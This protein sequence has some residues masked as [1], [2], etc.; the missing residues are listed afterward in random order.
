MTQGTSGSGAKTRSRLKRSAPRPIALEPRIMYDGAAVDT[1]AA[2]AAAAKQTSNTATDSNVSSES[3]GFAKLYVP[4]AVE[5]AAATAREIVFVDARVPDYQQLVAG[6]RSDVQVIVI[7]AD[8]DGLAVIDRTLA[9]R[10]DI[11]AVHVVTHGSDGTFTLGST[12]VDADTLAARESE[13]SAWSSSL[14]STADLLLYGCDVAASDAGKALVNK[15]ATLTGADVAASVDD[16]GSAT[17]GGNWTLEY[18]TGS[19]ESQSFLT[20]DAATSYQDRLSAFNLSGSTG[21]TAV[22]Y[23]VN[24]DPVGDSQ[25]GAADTDIVG[26]ANHGSLYVAFDD[27]GTAT[28]ADDSVVYRLRIDNPTSST[29][30]GGV[31]VV[32]LD[33]NLDGRID[34]FVSV[35]GRNN[36]QA[37]KILDPGTG[38]NLSPNTTSTSPL[39]TGWLANNGVYSFSASNYSV[40]AVS[41]STDPN[42]N[43]DTDL[44][45]DGKTDVFVNWRVSVSDLATVLAKPS[46]VDRNGVYGPRGSTGITGFTENTSIQYVNFTQTQ[47]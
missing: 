15:L 41:A 21:W 4:L 20:A 37:I 35:D 31:A 10:T 23:G 38:L 9:G 19:I 44:G 16:T 40:V 11:T 29:Y 24:K 46:P 27:N 5:P 33:V 36:G 45:N 42:W 6:A 18:S 30:F 34:V 43:G 13:V 47:T 2:A 39:P 12:V 14:T 26:D 3:A 1:A 28:T 17:G 22:M 7:Q 32:G 25:A 8:E